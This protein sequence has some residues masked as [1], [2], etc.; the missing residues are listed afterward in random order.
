MY[1]IGVIGSGHRMTPLVIRTAQNEDFEIRAVCDP[2]TEEVKKKY[3]EY[4]NVNF[5]TDAKKMLDSE[6]LDCLMIGTRCSLHTSFMMLAA[7][8]GLPVFLEKPVCTNE[9]QLHMLE[10][11][12]DVSDKVV[13]SF[14]L[15]NTPIV[16]CVREII[17]SGKI[18]QVA[19]VQAYN[20]VPYARCY[21]HSW[22][23]DENETGGLWLQKATHDFDYINSLLENVQPVRICAVSSKQI[24][25]GDMPCGQKCT[26]CAHRKTCPESAENVAG[27]GDKYEVNNSCCFAV[28]T[29]N[30][31]SGSAIIEYSNGMHAVYSQDFIARK[32]A[33]KRGARLIGYYGTV[34]FDFVTGKV[35][36]YYHNQDLTET[37]SFAI[38]HGHS[39][40]DTALI[41]NFCDVVRKTDVSHSPLNDGI[42]SAKMCML[43][44]KSAEEKIFCNL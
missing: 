44:K 27:Y 24:F 7:E 2:N 35:Q 41:R 32:G 6:D 18:G 34:E 21:Y 25:K 4:N 36:V 13:V 9:K 26:D 23:R 42:L 43:A 10:S 40:G 38:G 12:K 31:D 33:G 30:Q 5:Y 37:H 8:Y 14:P 20:N 28:D 15:R 17:R 16:N 11:L 29:G 22:Y 19:H 1:K 3:A 39:G